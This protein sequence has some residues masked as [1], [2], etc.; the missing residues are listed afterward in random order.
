MDN[1]DCIQPIHLEEVFQSKNPRLARMLPG[2]VYAFLKRLIH[3]DVIN[4]FIARYGDRQGKEFAH[5]ILE[6]L[7][8]SYDVVGQENLPDKEGRYIF[9]SNHP[10]GGPDGIVLISFLSQYYPE[11]KFPVNDILLNLKNLNNIFLPVNKHGRF[12]K[13]A[14]EAIEEAYRSDTQMIMFP[15]GLVSRKQ[16]GVVKDLQWQK[17]FVTKAVEHHRDVVP[18]FFSGHN[19]SFFYNLANFRKRIHLKANIE[20]LWLPDETL[21]NKGQHFTIHIGKPIPYDTFD[22]SKKP[23]DWAAW[24]KEKVYGMKE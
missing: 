17:S 2:F 4:D 16:S 24:V 22:N 21:K 13:E 23:L 5:A 10:L 18:I 7:E 8:V 1:K 19:S 6:F 14:A 20:M 11:L 12:S 15:A 3:V 9:V